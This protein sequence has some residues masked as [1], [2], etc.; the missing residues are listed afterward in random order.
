M[1]RPP[2]WTTTAE[3][4]VFEREPGIAAEAH[5]LG[6][7]LARGQRVLD[8][9]CAATGRSARLARSFG[10]TVCSIDVNSEAIGRFRSRPDADGIQ[11]FP[12]SV[13]HLP[14]AD[15]AFDMVL[16]ALHGLDYLDEDDVKH[17][18]MALREAAR[19][20]GPGGALVF[21]TNNPIGAIL[22]PRAV[23]HLG[24]LRWRL[25]Q[26]AQSRAEGHG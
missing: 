14:F 16:I 15:N 17:R 8:V 12:A 19:V 6:E 4:H 22:S 20:L 23:T 11:A 24:Y 10:G 21:N 7:N 26:L 25:A 2:N 3:T 18:T 1:N 13:T 9:G 5:I